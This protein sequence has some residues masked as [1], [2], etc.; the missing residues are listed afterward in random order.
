MGSR[1][2]L[3][4]QNHLEPSALAKSIFDLTPLDGEMLKPKELIEIRGHNKLTLEDRRVF[5]KLIENAWGPELSKVGTWF[6]IPTSDLKELTGGKGDRLKA[7]IDALMTTFAVEVFQKDGV[8][9]ERRVPLLSTNEIEV[10]A[11][12]GLF[13]YKLPE[14]L[15]ELVANSNIFAKLDLQVMKS[16]RSKFAFSLYEALSLRIRMKHKFIEELS[17][18]QM[19]NLLGVEDGKLEA[20]K[21]LNLKAIK[22]AVDEVNAITPYQVSIL[23]VKQGKKVVGFKMGWNVKSDEGLKEAYSEL[24]RHS[25]GR[26]PRASGIADDPVSD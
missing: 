16:F 21:N 4:T 24:N 25:K 5:N 17:L 7:A 14:E 19:R 6:S 13:S 10:S 8:P 2:V 15:A 3:A 20:Y 9:Y 22:P 1:C 23:P 11:N 12:S 26:G 18:D